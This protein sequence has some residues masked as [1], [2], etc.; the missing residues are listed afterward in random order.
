MLRRALLLACVAAVLAVTLAHAADY[1]QHEKVRA[2]EHSLSERTSTEEG[3][4][5]GHTHK[6]RSERTPCV[7]LTGLVR[8][9]SCCPAS[10]AAAAAGAGL[11]QQRGGQLLAETAERVR[12]CLCA[13]C[14]AAVGS[15]SCIRSCAALSLCLPLRQPFHNPA[16]SYTYYSLPYCM[17]KSLDKLPHTP[18]DDNLGEV[19][20]GDRRRASLYDIRYNVDIQWTA[21]CHFRLS[22][23]DIK[24]FI[25][26]IKQHYIYEMF[27]DDLAVKGFI[28]EMEETQ[29]KYDSHMHNETR[30]YLFT[31]LDFS[32]AYN[33]NNVIAVNLTT[34][35]R[36]KVELEFGK[37]VRQ[38]RHDALALHHT[39]AHT[40]FLRLPSLVSS[41]LLPMLEI[42][43][44]TMTVVFSFSLSRG[45][46]REN[47]PVRP[48]RDSS[49]PLVSSVNSAS[50]S[51]TLLFIQLQPVPFFPAF[52]HGVQR[53][54]SNFSS[55]CAVAVGVAVARSTWS[56][57]TPPTGFRRRSSTM[58][59]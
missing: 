2:S 36:E 1:K 46:G 8:T 53:L 13:E 27:V 58:I 3:E 56:S 43:G 40:L 19:L 5:D 22:Q 33:G 38:Q 20:A 41:P 12:S 23:D 34:D 42:F 39:L 11:C 51:A 59:A 4:R 24:Q 9:A 47:I 54:R 18:G 25:D 26:A 21:L 28:G 31:H 10:A 50:R 7:H 29:T 35:P 17:P 49:N 48:G 52:M 30:I 16:E 45:E 6:R 57:R 44:C 37:D 15:R 32:I 14:T 55:S